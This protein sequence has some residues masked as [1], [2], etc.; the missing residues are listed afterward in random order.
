MKDLSAQSKRSKEVL[1]QLFTISTI[2]T[3]FLYY[4]LTNFDFY[5]LDGNLTFFIIGTI[6]FAGTSTL[7]I[8]FST[9]LLV[10]IVAI[11]Y[12]YHL[13]KG[14]DEEKDEKSW[15]NLLWTHVYQQPRIIIVF[16]ISIW[17]I[18]ALFILFALHAPKLLAVLTFLLALALGIGI[19]VI[20]AISFIQIL[21]FIKHIAKY[22]FTL[23]LRFRSRKNNENNKN[24]V[25]KTPQLKRYPSLLSKGIQWFLRNKKE[26]VDNLKFIITYIISITLAT[27]F[28]LVFLVGHTDVSIIYDKDSYYE[29][30]SVNAIVE[31]SGILS[32]TI[33]MI[34]VNDDYKILV[35]KSVEKITFPS[36]EL[37]SPNIIIYYTIEN[38]FPKLS[39]YTSGSKTVIVPYFGTFPEKETE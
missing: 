12:N 31:I 8:L 5:S 1:L 14:R 27:I 24:V 32:P 25:I 36:E 6:A 13:M 17:I 16:G 38:A 9:Y 10:L 19:G 28:F 33:S 15:T 26:I 11:S 35:N 21:K 30:E 2:A 39:K 20:I 7:A 29:E 18:V 23:F 34:V 4:V 22:L 37:R 3:G